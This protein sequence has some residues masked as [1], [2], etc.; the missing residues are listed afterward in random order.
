MLEKV[1]LCIGSIEE[2]CS[3][4]YYKVLQELEFDSDNKKN[5]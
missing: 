5:N 1:L 3:Y 2:N 4:A